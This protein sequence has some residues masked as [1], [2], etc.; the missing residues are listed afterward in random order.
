MAILGSRSSTRE[1]GYQ[2]SLQENLE[3]ESS[4]SWIP[5]EFDCNRSSSSMGVV[6]VAGDGGADTRR[7]GERNAFR[8]R[9][10]G[11]R[12]LEERKGGGDEMSAGI[13]G[14][15]RREEAIFFSVVIWISEKEGNCCVFLGKFDCVE[16]VV[17][18]EK[19][20][21]R[22]VLNQFAGTSKLE[23]R[24]FSVSQNSWEFTVKTDSAVAVIFGFY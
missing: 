20:S 16:G 23:S 12:V 15:E 24:V 9:E 17:M 1:T 13:I 21:L 14:V 11:I 10:E 8:R 22:V 2:W 4:F 19:K 3:D 18:N 5:C 6:V 7:G